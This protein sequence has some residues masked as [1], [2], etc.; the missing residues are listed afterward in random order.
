MLFLTVGHCTMNRN[1]FTQPHNLHYP[2][3]G[4]YEYLHPVRQ[5]LL[6]SFCGHSIA[7]ELQG[8]MF[9][10]RFFPQNVPD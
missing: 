1:K 8:R 2:Q 6:C 3:T 9:G 4:I 5:K 10:S 7:L